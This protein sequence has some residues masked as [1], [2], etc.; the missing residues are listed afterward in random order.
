MTIIFEDG[1]ESGDFTAGDYSS[2]V[3]STSNGTNSVVNTTKHHDIYSYKSDINAGAT[4]AF[5]KQQFASAYSTLFYRFYVNLEELLSTN[6]ATCWLAQVR[7][8]TGTTTIAGFGLI[9]DVS[10]TKWY[11]GYLDGSIQYASLASPTPSTG[12]YYCVEIKTV[13]SATVGQVKIDIDGVE[14]FN[15]TDINTGTTDIQ[16][17]TL[18]RRYFSANTDAGTAYFDCVKI[19][20]VGPIGVEA[21][22]PTIKKGGNVAGMMTNMLN[23]K[24][25]YSACNRFPKLSVN[26]LI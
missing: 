23:S 5:I 13:V 14:A 17:V 16:N 19:A 8:A 15:Y 3:E 7:A 2:W 10:T 21:S 12:Q 20:D 25:L 4:Y 9:Q 22:G 11:C 6:A 1:F 26:K 24:M 18:G